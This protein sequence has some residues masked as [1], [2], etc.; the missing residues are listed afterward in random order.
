MTGLGRIAI[1]MLALLVVA[2][3]ASETTPGGAAFIVDGQA[4]QFDALPSGH[5]Y[6]TP[7][8][9]QVTTRP[10][11]DAVEQ[12]SITFAAIDLRKL[13]LPAEL[14]RPRMPDTPLDPMSAMVRVGFSYRTEEG[15]EWAGP[16]RVHIDRFGPDG[17]IEG[18]FD[19]IRLPHTDQQLPDITLSAGAF[20]AQISKP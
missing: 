12:L 19:G 15:V 8:A 3:A 6:Y 14:P 17:V 4:L 10:R 7:M 2:E 5:N 16:G 1:S 13:E 18:R 9:S 11:V 20:R